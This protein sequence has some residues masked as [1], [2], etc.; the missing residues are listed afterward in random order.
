MPF[1]SFLLKNLMKKNNLCS[2]EGPAAEKRWTSCGRKTDA[3]HKKNRP[4]LAPE[5]VRSKD[6]HPRTIARLSYQ[7]LLEST[8][9]NFAGR[10][11]DHVSEAC[12]LS[13]SK[14]ARLSVAADDKKARLVL[15][16]L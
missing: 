5:A 15:P 10:M 2:W 6:L 4:G 12:K 3:L 1:D 8:S 11:G 16:K 9:R 7:H 13:K 14:L